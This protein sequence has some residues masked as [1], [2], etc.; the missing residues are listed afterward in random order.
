MAPPTYSP[1]LIFSLLVNRWVPSLYPY[2]YHLIQSLCWWI[3]DREPI[4]ISPLGPMAIIHF[5]P[6][7]AEPQWF[8]PL[9]LDDRT[10]DLQCFLLCEFEGVDWGINIAHGQRAFI[11]HEGNKRWRS[12][13]TENLLQL[14]SG[15][16]RTTELDQGILVSK[17][18]KSEWK[19]GSITWCHTT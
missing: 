10:T 15:S 4:E 16:Q 5:A 11:G 17:G 18:Y 8:G 3:V 1:A 9:N 7:M 13:V 2:S 12:T 19:R 6:D 14:L